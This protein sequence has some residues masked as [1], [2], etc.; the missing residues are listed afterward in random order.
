MRT[1]LFCGGGSSGHV[2]P[3]IA[4]AETLIK[5]D[6]ELRAS[7]VIADREDEKKL[8]HDAGFSYDVLRAGK[9]PRGLSFRLVTF[10]LL[11]MISLVQ[12]VL[13]FRRLKPSLV[14]SKGGYISVP[15]CL[16]A[17][18]CRIPIILHASDSVPSMSDRLIG[19]IA[20]IICTGFS[21]TQFP[22]KL[23]SK[24]QQTGNPIRSIISTASR[25][26][27]RR[28]TGF[29]GNRPVV[30][31]IGGSQGSRALNDHVKKCLEELLAMADVIHL[32]GQ[33]KNSAHDHARYFAREFVTDELPHLYALADIV[34]TRAGAGA[35][36]ELA[37]LAKAT[38]VVP[39]AGV[40]HDHQVRNAEALLKADACVVLREEH[41]SNLAS[42]ITDLLASRERKECL[43]KNFSAFFPRDAAEKISKTLLDVLEVTS[44]QS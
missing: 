13:L 24:I 18:F 28:I 22:E 41:L 19:R 38:I 30:M 40:A 29:S 43:G 5:K 6:G 11:I 37:S 33:G 21:D 26:A 27:G 4:V 1:I 42:V 7:F 8:V 32:T 20:T 15:V 31:I 35:L 34:V 3:S 9:F 10:P 25:D 44:L 36:S 17:R 16:I 12:S 23:R 14:F 39:L 2:V